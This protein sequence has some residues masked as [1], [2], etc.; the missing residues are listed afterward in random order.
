MPNATAAAQAI[1]QLGAALGIVVSGLALGPRDCPNSPL[2]ISI[3]VA[4][5]IG[6][7]FTVAW[8]GFVGGL[9]IAVTAALVAV[10]LAAIVVFRRRTIGEALRVADVRITIGRWLTFAAWSLGLLALVRSYSGGGWAVDWVEHWQ[11]AEFFFE[12]QPLGTKFGAIYSLPARPPLANVLTAVWQVFAGHSFAAYQVFL[13][14]FGT[15]VCLPVLALF[16]HWSVRPHASS[17][18]VLLLLVNPMVAQNVT[19]AWTKLPTAFFVLT[20]IAIL[21]VDLR[22]PLRNAV[23][24]AAICFGF[25]VLTH[26]SAV[27][28]VV[29]TALAVAWASRY[30]EP[31]RRQWQPVAIACVLFLLVVIPWF[32]WTSVHYGIAGTAQSNTT[33]AAWQSQTWAQRAGV[34]LANLRDTLVPFPLRGEPGDLIQQSSRIGRVRDLAFNL[35]QANL[36]LAIGT[37]GLIV[38]GY[39]A[40]RHRSTSASPRTTA[41]VAFLRVLVPAAIVLG[42]FAHTPRDAWGLAHI[43]LQPLVLIG[44]AWAAAQL[45]EAKPGVR[46]AWAAFAAVD[47]ALGIGLQLACESWAVVPT[48]AGKLDIAEFVSSLTPMAFANLNDKRAFNFEFFADR[49]ALSPVLVAIILLAIL[50]L[51]A[52]GAAKGNEPRA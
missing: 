29:A 2:R 10:A 51:T 22:Q 7:A 35:Y 15:L 43:C 50:G 4:S 38:L 48:V 19:F 32:G 14:L 24:I 33:A 18:A 8:A 16:Q 42:V 31:E 39:G 12:R 34:A 47:V 52:A 45:S 17:W 1:G 3:G 11:R 37:A 28:W 23:P 30:A 46:A 25:A 40:A 36:P 5:V 21:L 6:I 26:Y 13:T 27:P 41:E 49:M 20:A 9:P 44:L